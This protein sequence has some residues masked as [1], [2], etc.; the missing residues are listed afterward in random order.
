[1]SADV[2]FGF[3]HLTSLFAC[4]DILVTETE[5]ENEPNK[6]MGIWSF[7]CIYSVVYLDV[8][9]AQLRPVTTP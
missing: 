3:P 9:R 1:M 6:R 4:N 2:A 8:E 7:H 5:T